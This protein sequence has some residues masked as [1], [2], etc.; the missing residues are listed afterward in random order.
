MSLAILI[1]RI[2]GLAREQVFA[3]C[4]GGGALYDAFVAAFRIPNLLRDLF[5]EG[6]L[7]TA[8]VTV[9]SRRKADTGSSG[10]WHLARRVMTLQFLILGVIVLLGIFFAP[11]LL[12]VIALG[13]R[14]HPE[15]MALTITLTRI[16]FPFILF[17]GLAAL[18]MGMLNTFGRFG[19]PASASSFFNAGSILIGLGLALIFDSAFGETAMICMAIGV[20]GGGILQWLVQIP[21]LRKLGYRFRP[22]WAP[23]DPDVVEIG[24]LMAPAVVGVSAVQINVVINTMFASVLTS[25]SMSWMAFAFR[26]IQLPIGMFGVSISTVSLP[27]LAVEAASHDRAAFRQRIEKALRLNAALCIPAA[28]GLAF[29]SVP[30]VAVLFEHGRFDMNDTFQTANI[31]IAYAI[32]LVGYASLKVLTSPFYA[33]GRPRT[34]TYVSLASILLTVVLNWFFIHRTNFG[35]M[36]LA[37]STSCSALFG[38]GILLAILSRLTGPFH[39]GTWRALGK[40]LTAAA[41]MSGMILLLQAGM[42]HFFP[43]HTFL[44]NLV[45]VTLG[46]GLGMMSYIALARILK[47]EEVAQAENILLRRL[48]FR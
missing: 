12:D 16:L 35:A 24:R 21:A 13:W 45:R 34:P 36:G 30:I 39:H 8:F 37:F 42:D 5:A 31:L 38:S 4:F 22:E 33:L 7:S 10:A 29:L 17:V 40:M 27:A 6:A 3:F 25:G 2:L 15:K 28:C 32:G 20:I 14:N 26:L 19:L 43:G 47:L 11:Q 48:G 9:F 23:A 44:L 1:S 46:I 41:G 18:A